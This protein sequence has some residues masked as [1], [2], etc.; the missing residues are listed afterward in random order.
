MGGLG[1]TTLAQLVYNDDR[2]QK[3]FTK[4]LWVC[5][6]NDFDVKRIL[7]KLLQ[8]GDPNG[9]ASYSSEG[10]EQLQNRARNVLCEDKFVLFL[11]D[12]WNEDRVVWKK[13]ENLLITQ[14]R[15]SK[16]VVTTRS[17]KVALIVRT[18]T[19]KPYELRGLSDDEC[20][21]ILVKWAFKEGGE[22]KHPNLVNI[23]REIEKKCGGVPLAARTLGALLFSKINEH[24]WSSVRD[25]EMWAIVQK[26]ND[27][28]PI[29]R[30]SYDQMPSYLKPCFQYC[31]LFE[32]DE[33]IYGRKLIYAWIA[34][35]YVQC[36][37]PNEELEDI[38]EG[39]ILELVR[40]SFLELHYSIFP[41]PVRRETHK[42][43]DLVYDLAQYVPG[44]ECLT[45]KG[46][47]PEAIPDTIRHVSFG[48]N[49]YCTFPRP[50]MEAKKLR[51]IFYPVKIGPTFGSSIEPEIASFGCLRVLDGRDFDDSIS[52][53]ENIGKLKL[54]RYISR[55]NNLPK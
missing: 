42:M 34:L 10:L 21:H 50:L 13:L 6:S 40:R 26:E 5:I 37:D 14:G 46:A 20:L 23:A 31:S 16:I 51:T 1:K 12:V 53:P 45:I 47:I 4:R 39:Y 36:L 54:L 15:G 27:V 28:L 3:H 11:D 33:D 30:L 48:S 2:I 43:H 49:T 29:L 55:A 44:N 38:G 24:D 25:S 35:G 8:A 52:L 32:K 41:I 19:V 7:I 9:D 18:S 17:K 22:S